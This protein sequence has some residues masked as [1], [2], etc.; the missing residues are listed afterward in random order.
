MKFEHRVTIAAP[1]EAVRAFLDDVPRSARCLPGL[2]ELTPVGNDT[3]EGRV[4]VRVGPLA[5]RIGGTARLERDSE[6]WRLT[7]EGRD[8]RIGAGVVAK[9]EAHLNDL[10]PAGTELLIAADVQFSGRLA[11][12]GQPLI[13]RKADA[14]VKEFAT[15]IQKA[16]T[17]AA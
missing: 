10:T 17:G 15:N 9:V 12:L 5:L 14:M 4:A 8:R 13:R 3:Y 7:G 1:R 6:R 11:E 2:E 16:V